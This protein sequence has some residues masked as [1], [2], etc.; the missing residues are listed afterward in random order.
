M[1]LPLQLT[2][3]FAWLY[4]LSHLKLVLRMILNASFVPVKFMFHI[5]SLYINE[6]KNS[7]FRGGLNLLCTY[8]M[9]SV[10]LVALLIVISD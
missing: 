10:S 3:F 5:N 9:L 8:L 2:S 6:I 1:P 4:F 7:L